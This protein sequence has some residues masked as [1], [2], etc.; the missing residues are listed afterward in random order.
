MLATLIDWYETGAV[1][2]ESERGEAG[3]VK[4][5][6]LDEAACNKIF[7]SNSLL[8]HLKQL[9]LAFFHDFNE[10]LRSYRDDFLRGEWVGQLG[11]DN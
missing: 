9:T 11:V 3:E 10:D 2:P 7:Q 5:N 4:V 1:S 6:I 8:P